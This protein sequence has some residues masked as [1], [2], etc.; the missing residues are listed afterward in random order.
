MELELK[1][2]RAI[3]TGS[4]SGIGIGIAKA[5]AAEGAIVMVQGRNEERCQA[6]VAEIKA[7][8]GTADYVLGD[9]ALEEG[10]TKVAEA[11]NT[12][13]GGIDI[14]VNNTGGRAASQRGT[15]PPQQSW[16][17]VAWSDWMW[18]YEQNLGSS[19]R[20]IQNLVPGMKERGFGRV[21]NI[22][23]IVATQI[24][25]GQPEY[26]AAKAAMTN[27][28]VS[29]AHALAGTGITVNTVSPGTIVTPVI[30]RMMTG[31]AES[32][33]V[34]PDDWGAIEKKMTHEI[35]N[36]PVRRFGEPEEI[37]RVVAM[38]ASPLFSYITGSNYRVDG[39]LVRSIN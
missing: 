6:V 26:H 3:V 30:K 8:G 19:V 20:L 14:L 28:S 7:E 38:L 29:L 12:R 32:L 31:M 36:Q 24:T 37:G 1:G 15:A 22:G 17:E 10:T 16:L 25:Q 9:L 23:S 27:M 35:Q 11:V 39:G 4:S 33:G 2:L 21:I 18:T 34:D 13:L 5:L